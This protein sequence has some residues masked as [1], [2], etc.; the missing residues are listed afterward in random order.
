M[1]PLGYK[2]LACTNRNIFFAPK[3]P[4]ASLLALEIEQCACG[5]GD[6]SCGDGCPEPPLHPP[7]RF[8]VLSRAVADAEFIDDGVCV[9]SNV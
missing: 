4:F 6:Y 1:S 9:M 3:P 2:K 5:D 8:K 7:V